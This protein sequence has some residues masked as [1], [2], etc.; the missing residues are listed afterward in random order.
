MGSVRHATER[1]FVFH[2]PPGH[3]SWVT[4][5]ELWFSIF[6]KRSLRNGSLKSTAELEPVVTAFIKRC[7][8]KD[9]HPFSWTLKGYPLEE[10]AREVAAA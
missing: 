4:Q 8:T 3:A 7:N 9:K 6:A 10:R 2:F 5:L 1:G